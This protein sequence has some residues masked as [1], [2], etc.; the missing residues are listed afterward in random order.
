[1]LI[2]LVVILLHRIAMALIPSLTLLKVVL[3]QW[4]VCV[5]ILGSGLLM[6]K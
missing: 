2:R 3:Y 1:M 5:E 6:I 4:R